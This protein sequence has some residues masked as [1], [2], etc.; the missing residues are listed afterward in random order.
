M[1]KFSVIDRESGRVLAAGITLTEAV[2][3]RDA[4]TTLGDPHIVSGDLIEGEVLDPRIV[5]FLLE[6]AV[7]EAAPKPVRHL[8]VPSYWSRCE[9]CGAQGFY[10]AH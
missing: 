3:V 4:L 7:R 1:E 5:L 2:R 8:H 9:I 6:G 10:N